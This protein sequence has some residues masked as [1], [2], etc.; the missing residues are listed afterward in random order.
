MRSLVLFLSIGSCFANFGNLTDVIRT[1]NKHNREF[2]FLKGSKSHEEYPDLQQMHAFAEVLH[3]YGCWCYSGRLNMG[4][5]R[6]T[7]IDKFDEVCRAMAQAYYCV[8]V[9][10]PHNGDASCDPVQQS[11]AGYSWEVEYE[12]QNMK[13]NTILT[14]TGD[15]EDWCEATVC[16]IDMLYT[17]LYLD[18]IM[19]ALEPNFEDFAHNNGFNPKKQCSGD[20]NGSALPPGPNPPSPQPYKRCCGKYPHRW[21]YRTDSAT[22]PNR[23]CCDLEGG[24]NTGATRSR[25]F[26]T[27]SH[28]CCGE[29][30]V[31]AGD[32][33]M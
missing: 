30:G 13:V 27:E 23:K 16:E 15:P 28:V 12:V 25:T 18:L 4:R 24:P 5:G 32:K 8:G 26:L 10:G 22:D 3:E 9:D 2:V 17:K 31:Q 29:G 11:I 33:C 20:D 14:C 6:G 19:D 21:V 7:P 1:I